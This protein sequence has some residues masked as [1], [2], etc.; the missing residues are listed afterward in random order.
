MLRRTKLTNLLA[1]T[2]RFRDDSRGNLSVIFSVVAI[3]ALAL[4]GASIDY[5]RSTGVISQA[6]AA[7]DA[8][9]LAAGA[10]AGA[11][12]A[13]RQ[14]IATSTANGYFGAGAAKLNMTI[15]E[16]DVS[17]GL[18]EVTIT[19]SMPTI[20][21]K[22]LGKSRM[23]FSVTSR[24]TTNGVSDSK[25]LEM[26]LALDNTGSMSAN[27]ADLKSAA[28]T[29]VDTVMG[30]GGGAARVS[31]VPYVAAVNPGLT[32]ATSVAS[33]IDT[34]MA[35][36]F[37]GIWQ[38]GAW[39]TYG[40]PCGSPYWGGGG[41]GGGGGGAGSG[42]TG[43]ARDIIDILK[44]IRH[45]AMELFGVS[46]A[47]AEDVTPNTVP[48]LTTKS[49]KSPN[50]GQTYTIPKGFET[51]TKD[52][53]GAY[54]TGGCDW[55]ANPGTVSHYELFKRVKNPAGGTVSWKGCVEARLSKKE[56]QWVNSHWGW[57]LSA[58][59]DYDISEDAPVAGDTASLY[60][61]YFAPDEPDY[62]PYTWAYVAPGA[63][64]AANKGFHNNYL[65]DGGKLSSTDQGSIPNSWNW[66]QLGQFDWSGGQ[67]LLKYDG[68]TN[69]DIIQ[70]TPDANGYTYGPNMGCPDPIL[71]LTNVKADVTAKINNL[72][73]WQSGGTIISEGVAWAWRTLS[74]NKP[75]ADGKP[76]AT[77]G[78]QK[79]IVLMTDGVN[80]LIDNANNASGYNSA[81]VSDYSSYGYLG[82]AR[83]WSVNNIQ[84]YS[85][86]QTH[87][88]NRVKD[89]CTAAKNAGVII[90]TVTFSHTG[91]LTSSQ[92]AAA[93]NLMRNCASKTTYSYVATDSATLQSA[94]SAIA[95][96]ATSGTLRLVK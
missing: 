75:F 70:E 46:S 29:L 62:S 94:F 34:Q 31:I 4:V 37:N 56:Q 6:Q 74:P 67:Y 49:W 21:S 58:S 22:V 32:D 28:L 10:Q 20:V 59:K 65:K 66:K 88:D 48:P 39:L 19:G 43:D 89:A 5:T 63:Y 69:A 52:K 27:M 14:T 45:L 77:T 11:T 57:G 7:A 25:P 96:S 41:G 24:A 38:R 1:S 42:G 60:V 80:E 73:Y 36:P 12:Q 33:Y 44:P 92:Q 85:G 86:F 47:H 50:S 51:V 72:K 17:P 71:R 2:A 90:Y 64:S 26:A 8:A 53:W 76:Y 3:P 15:T 55:L 30:S 18:Y 81:H 40:K 79:V 16:T 78:L 68:T 91:Y 84:T 54:S 13:A 95:V 35:N 82:G 23:Q 83:L 9:V 87:L 93:Q 61:P